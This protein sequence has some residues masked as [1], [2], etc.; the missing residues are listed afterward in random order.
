MVQDIADTYMQLQPEA[1]ITVESGGSN[2][3]IKSLPNKE[4]YLQFLPKKF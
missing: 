4:I 1:L 2:E 3:G